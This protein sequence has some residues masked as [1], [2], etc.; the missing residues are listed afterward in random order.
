MA[1]TMVDRLREALADC[2]ASE[3]RV[4][5]RLL[6][7]YPMSGLHS[8]SALARAVAVSTPTVLRLTTRLGFASYAAFQSALRDELTAQLSSPLSKPGAARQVGHGAARAPHLVFADAVCSNVRETFERLSA[9]E[10]EAISALLG[11]P[12]LRVHVV[13]GRFTDALARYLSVQLRILRPGVNHLDDQEANWVDQVLDFGKRD[14]LVVF[15]I[16]RYQANLLRLA[17]LAAKRGTRVIVFTDQWL[18]PVARHAD[19]VLS[20][21]I[22]VPSAWD[23]SAALL[24][25]A[26]ALLAAVTQAGW[27]AGSKRIREL[28]ALRSAMARSDGSTS[29]T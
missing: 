18:S 23:S 21:R 13:G 29:A 12:R 1:K 27:T 6:G 26:E 11:N 8:A 28:E 19:H 15:D 17:Q 24:V 14:V 22:A 10:F 20:A 25:I 3:R 4:A 16:R 5:Q 7:D 2:P 9:S